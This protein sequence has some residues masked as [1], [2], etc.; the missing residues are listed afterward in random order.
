MEYL[1]AVPPFTLVSVGHKWYAADIFSTRPS[2][3]VLPLLASW[4]EEFKQK[5]EHLMMKPTNRFT[6]VRL[7]IDEQGSWMVF[8]FDRDMQSANA[9][10]TIGTLQK[11]IPAETLLGKPAQL[12][13]TLHPFDELDKERLEAMQPITGFRPPKMPRAPRSPRYETRL[14]PGRSGA[15]SSDYFQVQ[16]AESDSEDSDEDMG[17][18]PTATLAILAAVGPVTMCI[19]DVHAKR[20]RHDLAIPVRDFVEDWVEH[21]RENVAVAVVIGENVIQYIRCVHEVRRQQLIAK[22][23]DRSSTPFSTVMVAHDMASEGMFP[24]FAQSQYLMKDIFVARCAV[25]LAMATGEAMIDKKEFRQYADI[26]TCKMGCGKLWTE[27]SRADGFCAPPRRCR[28]DFEFHNGGLCLNSACL[29]K[30]RAFENVDM[31]CSCTEDPKPMP[32]CCH[33]RWAFYWGRNILHPSQIYLF[34][35][36]HT[37]VTL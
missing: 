30:P 9:K 21:V 2:C 6:D 14:F 18:T 5:V 37:H 31:R 7:Y 10:T 28:Y 22:R 36:R 23:L 19:E 4:F 29:G 26:T 3:N 33:C 35:N 1:R 15:G 16:M 32:V 17:I 13:A 20:R 25:A 27:Q 24:S 11:A 8:G 34:D 12:I